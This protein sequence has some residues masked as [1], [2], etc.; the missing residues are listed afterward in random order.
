MVSHVLIAKAAFPPPVPTAEIGRAHA[1][2]AEPADGQ[3]NEQGK[4][5]AEAQ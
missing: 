4:G 5:E 3:E 2:G 1:E